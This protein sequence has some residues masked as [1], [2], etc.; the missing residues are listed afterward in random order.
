MEEIFTI[1]GFL[2]VRLVLNK[3]LYSIHET[4]PQGVTR[5]GAKEDRAVTSQNIRSYS[6]GL[7]SPVRKR[8][9]TLFF[10][11]GIQKR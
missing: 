4:L 3:S 9:G 7:N 6:H 11:K 8:A 5:K 10:L 2:E 1:R